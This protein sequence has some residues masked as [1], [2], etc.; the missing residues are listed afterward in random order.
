MKKFQELYE[1]IDRAV[2]SRK[3]PD[4]SGMAFKTALRLFEA[5]LKEEE[6]NS[7]AEFSKNIDQ[8]YQSVASKNKNFSASSLATYKSRISKVLTDYEKYGVDP[9]KMA[10]W[11]VKVITRSKKVPTITNDL[12]DKI[13]VIDGVDNSA[14]IFDFAGGVKLIIPRT[15][16][17]TDAL[18]DGEL[19]NI[20]FELRDFSERYCKEEEKETENK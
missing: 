15:A 7:I 9:T 8:I 2:K 14:H 12:K 1:F 20:K 19:K 17:A 11:S 4:N 5:D 6:R 10:N 3:Y 18:F 13:S 16:R